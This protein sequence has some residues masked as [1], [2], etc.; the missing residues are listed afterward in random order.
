[1]ID[2]FI[3]IVAL[4]ALFSGWRAGVI[5]ELMSTFGI[6][7]GLLIAATCY[8]Y[9]HDFLAV[10]GSETNMVTSIIAFLLL[11]IIVPIALGFVA[12][13]LTR[14]LKTFRLGMPNAILGAVVCLLKY[15]VILSCVF[16]VMQELS[17]MNQEKVAT[18]KL[19]TPVAGALGMFFSDEEG[20]AEGS[21]GA[22]T[23]AD[24]VSVQKSDT[25]WV[26][27]SSH[28]ADTKTK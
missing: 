27:M 14:S 23:P 2:L 9:G 13:V 6:L 1:M 24:S 5:N 8:R 10:N 16:N 17:I 3:I 18:S 12:N 11:W 25:I 7:V 28:K 20:S 15:L 21:N 22:A 19:Y 4:W 26:D